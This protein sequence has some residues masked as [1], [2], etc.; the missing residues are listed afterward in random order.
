M[1][2][3][4]RHF[5]IDRAGRRE[6]SRLVRIAALALVLGA[7]HFARAAQRAPAPAPPS[8]PPPSHEFQFVKSVF[9]ASPGFGKDPFYPRSHRMMHSAPVNPVES[10][11]PVTSLVLKGISGPRNHRLA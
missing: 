11:A 6:C 1:K 4:Y 9:V 7:P 2:R 5:P 10:F 8:S 3:L